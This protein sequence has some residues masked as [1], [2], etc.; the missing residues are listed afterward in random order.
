MTCK[1]GFSD[2][3]RWFDQRFCKKGVRM[4]AAAC[5]A[6]VLADV[7]FVAIFDPSYLR[8]SPRT[9]AAYRVAPRQLW[10]L[11]LIVGYCASLICYGA[12]RW[13][14][15]AR[16]YADYLDGALAMALSERT[17]RRARNARGA[18]EMML[19]V[20]FGWVLIAI[21]MVAASFCAL[22][23]LGLVGSCYLAH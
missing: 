10:E 21:M 23:I 4:G 17:D 11:V 18:I 13:D 20:D 1:D 16:R 14:S 19:N 7:L 2:D 9:I 3:N 8:C 5:M 22:P 12:I 6:V 15:L